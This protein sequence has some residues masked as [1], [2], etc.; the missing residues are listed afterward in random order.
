MNP[1]RHNAIV[2]T[3]KSNPS[4]DEILEQAKNQPRLHNFIM[5]LYQGKEFK[6][7]DLANF[8]STNY[9]YAIWTVTNIYPNEEFFLKARKI[10]G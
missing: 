9:G 3:F 6:I 10:N 8:D 2:N 5:S 7:S 1:Y 4:H